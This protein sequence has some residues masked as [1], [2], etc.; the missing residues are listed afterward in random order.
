MRLTGFQGIRPRTSPRLLG[1][2]VA[3]VASNV[4][5]ISGEARPTSLPELVADSTKTGP[6]LTL[7]KADDIWFTWDKDVDVC[8][9]P[10]PGAAK[11]VY[12]GDY[13]PRITTAALAAG[14]AAPTACRVLGVPAPVTAPTVTPSGGAL[15]DVTRYYCYTFYDDWDQESAPSALSAATTGKPD[16]T[17]AVTGMDIAPANSGDITAVTYVD[18][19]VTITTTSSHFNRAGERVA[20][21]GVTTVTSINGTWTLTA[22]DFA[23]KTMTFTVDTTPT[24][25]YN[26]ATDTTDTWVR[27][28]PHGTVTKRLY[29]TSGTTAQFQMVAEGITASGATAYDDTLSDDAIAGD[30]LISADWAMP[31]VD[32][33]GVMTLPSGSLCGFSGNEV[34][35]SEPFQPHAWP[36]AYR[37]RAKFPVVAVA[38]FTSGIVV[39]TTG[40]PSAII[41][42]EPGQMT[43][44]PVTGANPCLSKRSMIGL[45]DRVGYATAH[46]YFTI[47]DNGTDLLSKEWYSRDEWDN[48]DPVTM[49]AEAVRGRL[50]VMTQ[51]QGP[52]LLIFDFLDG[53]GLTTSDVDATELFADAISGKLYI[54][55]RSNEDI[56]E[57]DPND[58]VYMDMDWMSKE[59]ILPEPVN[60]G[61][62][63]VNFYS[64]WSDA[65][66]AALL[67][68]YNSD[69]AA[70]DALIA[71][72]R[73]VEGVALGA[74]DIGGEINGD[75]FNLYAVNDSEITYVTA[76][77]LEAPG[78]TFT[79][80]VDGDPYFSKTV[81]DSKGFALPSGYKSDTF[82]VR[83][84]GQSLVRSIDL[85]QTLS[86]L[87]NA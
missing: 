36:A 11:W 76:P 52:K 73:T 3:Q 17:W 38:Q 49:I 71:S 47:G 35:L 40:E 13:E 62:A 68:A 20:I 72:G 51:G 45:G 2:T 37:K 67:A 8:R 65:Q 21:A 25:V 22:V 41:G 14:D 30:E 26:D 64:R 1:D 32:L 23:A 6:L 84:Q 15:T 59:F 5:L 31:P 61:A 81:T 34:C 39:G 86:G 10:L 69:L 57:F 46:G 70:N 18:T 83:V 12:T 75:E 79:L 48:L 44:E 42:H 50:Y 9:S 82:A 43:V 27:E 80:Y 77:E 74:G 53:T 19:A 24:G 7:Y 78:V 63:R 87:K 60:L 33:A 58:G 29:R 85:A 66:Y 16:G 28:A 54:S 55:D 4:N 56:R